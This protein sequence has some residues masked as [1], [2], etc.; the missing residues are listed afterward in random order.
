MN[1]A[2]E[3]LFWAFTVHKKQVSM[4]EYA[5]V[6][7]GLAIFAAGQDYLAPSRAKSSNGSFIEELDRSNRERYTI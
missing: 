2:M 7:L 5:I 6:D 3:V 4:V 1:T